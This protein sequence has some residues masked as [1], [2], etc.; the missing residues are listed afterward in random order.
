[1]NDDSI[2]FGVLVIAVLVSSL[3]VGVI[4]SY[5]QHKEK[6]AVKVATIEQ[7]KK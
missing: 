6:E 7:V 2:P 1:M 5:D 3:T 4:R